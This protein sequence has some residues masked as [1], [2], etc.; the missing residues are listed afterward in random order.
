M[1]KVKPVNTEKSKDNQKTFEIEEQEQSFDMN[2]GT[3][4][5]SNTVS[6]GTKQPTVEEVKAKYDKPFFGSGVSTSSMSSSTGAIKKAKLA[7]TDKKKT[8]RKVSTLIR[9]TV[10]KAIQNENTETVVVPSVGNPNKINILEDRQVN[11][12]FS[13]E[14]M[15]EEAIGGTAIPSPTRLLN[16]RA[17]I[18]PDGIEDEF[19][20]PR[21]TI[22][23]SSIIHKKA[24]DTLEIQNRYD[25]LSD[26]SDNEE[27][28]EKR[29]QTTTTRKINLL[30][31]FR[32][33]AQTRDQKEIP[34]PRKKNPTHRQ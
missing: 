15:E 3:E 7:L 33:I 31:R 10:Q 9:E 22:P 8:G 11:R 6:K 12:S 29:M 16:K 26:S 17:S 4:T 18:S 27:L 30:K 21:K 32:Y 28:E 14:R 20:A 25:S 24:K 23:L 5:K 2:E 34:K 13:P 1:T 19:I